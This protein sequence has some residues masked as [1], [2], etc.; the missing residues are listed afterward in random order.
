M[1]RAKPDPNRE[2][3]RYLESVDSSKSKPFHRAEYCTKGGPCK[4]YSGC[5]EAHAVKAVTPT[6]EQQD[7]Q[8]YTESSGTCYA[9]QAELTQRDRAINYS[10]VV[11]SYPKR[12]AR[13]QVD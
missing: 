4:N 5:L 8:R 9:P 7:F 6:Q 13:T 12:S 10:R 1:P 3:N 11:A 2:F